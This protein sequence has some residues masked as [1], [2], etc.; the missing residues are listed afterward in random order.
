MVF[1]EYMPSSGIAGP[2]GSSVFSF[3]R[4]LHT[5]LHSGSISLHSYQQCKRVPFSLHPLQHLLFVDFMMMVILT[6]GRWYLIIVLVCIS[7]ILIDVKHLFM[8]LFAICIVF[9]VE[10]HKHMPVFITALFTWKQPKCPATD[11][12]IKKMYRWPNCTWK[13]VQNH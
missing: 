4:N 2:Y 1:S 7:L 3:L 6:S 5:V 10:N 8:C 11:A 12:L 13:D 9:L